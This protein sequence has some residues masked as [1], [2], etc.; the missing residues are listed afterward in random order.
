MSALEPTASSGEPRKRSFY[1]DGPIFLPNIANQGQG[2]ENLIMS[3]Q[4][5]NNN[6]SDLFSSPENTLVKTPYRKCHDGANYLS[7]GS[8]VEGLDPRQVVNDHVNTTNVFSSQTRSLNVEEHSWKD[9]TMEDKDPKL[10]FFKSLSRNPRNLSKN[11]RKKPNGSEREMKTQIQK[12]RNFRKGCPNWKKLMQ[13]NRQR[14]LHSGMFTGVT[15]MH[16][17]IIAASLGIQQ[18]Q[19]K[20]SESYHGC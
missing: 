13:S 5:L 19:A 2:A 7:P 6:L 9:E 14:M 15:R 16:P 10:R 12:S 20:V 4:R 17:E 3:P 11:L 1:I 18:L 8:P